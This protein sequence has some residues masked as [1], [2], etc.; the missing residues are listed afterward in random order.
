MAY[1]QFGLIGFGGN[2]IY[3]EEHIQTIS[4]KILGSSQEFANAISSMKFNM[5]GDNTDV[6]K[7]LRMAA[8]YPFRAG[9]AKSVVL[10]T[11]SECTEQ[12][13]RYN[14]IKHNLKARGIHLHVIMEH[15]F[16]LGASDIETPKTNYLFG[17]IHHIISI[18]HQLQL[19]RLQI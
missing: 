14:E 18:N 6:F 8:K 15:E 10:L 3:D 19:Y 11:C 4:G 16:T 17:K 13:A 12:A 7:A 1:N 5:E 9:V 2:G